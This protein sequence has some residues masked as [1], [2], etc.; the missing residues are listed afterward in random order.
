MKLTV[1]FALIGGALVFSVG[2]PGAANATCPLPA[3]SS[4]TPSLNQTHVFCGEISNKGDVKG[5]HSEVIVPPKAGNTVVSVVG[6]KSV[7]GDIFAGY[8]KFSNG[9]SKYS[10]FFPKSCTQAQIIASA[11][12][13]AS[14]GSPAH[15][16]GVVGLSAP[17][18]GGSTYCL[19]Q[20]AA[21]PMKVDPKKDKAGQLI[22]NTAFPL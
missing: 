12:Y 22:L 20:G 15:D 8:P 6:Q 2:V 18:T 4:T 19:N 11:L 9:K 5:Y 21:F 14:T 7:N 3:W 17:A 1:T 13:V 10:T 16:W